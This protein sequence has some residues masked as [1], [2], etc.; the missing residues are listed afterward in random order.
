MAD[1]HRSSNRQ[2][3]RARANNAS[4]ACGRA[5]R[6][7]HR[8]ARALAIAA[9]TTLALSCDTLLLP[10]TGKPEEGPSLRS[11]PKGTIEQ[12]FRAYEEKRIDLFTELLPK[13]G[14]YR[15]FI[16]PD[17]GG[18]YAAAHSTD[19]VIARIEDSQ[20]TYVKS[21]SYYYWGQESEI[22]KH[23]RLFSRAASIEFT[24]E[25]IID[26]SFTYKVS[27]DNDTAV[28]VRLT[29]GELCIEARDTL[30]C[31]QK[32]G[33][34]QVFL[35]EREADRKTGDRL[36]VIKDWFDLDYLK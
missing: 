2:G 29:A 15:F 7:E 4:T 28:E 16:S 14:T 17:Y 26:E 18:A 30:F 25:P 35:L 8:I 32:E 9:L 22:A 34:S 13:N 24:E 23:R 20:Y 21:G 33:Q 36:W 10:P 11:T 31:T 5:Y 1:I 19:A 3:K 27:A 12:L 6:G